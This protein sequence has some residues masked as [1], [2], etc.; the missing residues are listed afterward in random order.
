VPTGIA[1][2]GGAFL[3][4]R[5]AQAA[6]TLAARVF[7]RPGGRETLALNLAVV[8]V[9]FA[10]LPFLGFGDYGFYDRYLIVFLPPLMAVLVAPLPKDGAA[11]Q[12][13]ARWA[14][15]S[16]V[17]LMSALAV[18]TLAATHDYLAWNRVRWT[19]LH[20]LVRNEGAPVE[21]IFG[22]FEFNGWYLYERYAAAAEPDWAGSFWVDSDE[23][24]VAFRPLPGH[25]TLGT[26]P[27]PQWLPGPAERR[28]ILT[29]RRV[30]EARGAQ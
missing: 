21:R 2:L 26:Y 18:F 17:V 12:Q 29:Q 15:R 6:W 24:T 11:V 1:V 25:E 3:A 9:G 10:P 28:L 30:P 20:D 19:A 23:Y 13:P 14:F 5:L 16:S 8:A 7:G 4:V 22:G 27:V